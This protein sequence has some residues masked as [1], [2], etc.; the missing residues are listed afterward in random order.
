MKCAWCIVIG[1]L[2]SGTAAAAG[3]WSTTFRF[4]KPLILDDARDGDIA[5]FTLDRDIYAATRDQIP[6]LRIVTDA[7]IEVPFQLERETE[8]LE[9]TIRSSVPTEFV[10]LRETGKA[11]EL[12]LRPL[13]DGLPIDELFSL[14]RKLDEKESPRKELSRTIRDGKEDERTERTIVDQR[15]FRIERIV[16]GYTMKRLTAHRTKSVSADFAGFT[17]VEDREGKCTILT[18]RSRREPVTAITPK[19]TVFLIRIDSAFRAG[20][21]GSQQFKAR[22]VGIDLAWRQLSLGL[23]DRSR[24]A[25]P[26]WFTRHCSRLFKEYPGHVALESTWVGA[27]V[28]SY[29]FP[30]A[31]PSPRAGWRAS[32]RPGFRRGG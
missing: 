10:A 8:I 16:A 12:K 24:H 20:D 29:R 15:T 23:P 6:D 4:S 26:A 3:D 21:T 25:F 17:Q 32:R 2:L 5:A 1:I 31:W 13:G 11:I 9:E 19:V 22:L 30:I 28:G 7:G 27:G 18:V 14:R